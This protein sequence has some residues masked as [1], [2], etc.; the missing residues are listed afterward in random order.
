MVVVVVIMKTSD[1]IRMVNV[2]FLLLVTKIINGKTVNIKK[3]AAIIVHITEKMTSKMV[4]QQ[5]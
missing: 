3:K 5:R 2:Q 4:K 1:M